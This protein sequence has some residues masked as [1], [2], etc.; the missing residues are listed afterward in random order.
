VN[1]FRRHPTAAA[2]LG[3]GG[4]ALIAA[5]VV[6]RAGWFRPQP[7]LPDSSRM[8]VTATITPRSHYFGDIVNA[9][10]ELLFRSDR[11]LPSSVHV[12]A[13]FTPL[14]VVSHSLAREDAGTMTRLTYGFRVWCVTLPC[15]AQFE[16]KIAPPRAVVTYTPVGRGPKVVFVKWPRLTLASRRLIDPQRSRPL[17][18]ATVRPL[19]ATTYGIRPG[20]LAALAAAGSLLLLLVAIVLLVPAIPRSL[21]VRRPSWLRRRVRP[22]TPLQQALERVRVAS[23]NGGG[24]ERRALEQLA[25]ELAG[26]GEDALAR[27]ARRL[28]WSPGRP[29]ADGVDDLSSGVE[30]VIGAAR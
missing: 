13:P 29:S 20:L 25:V 15:L 26:T 18:E 24:D 9:R 3:I 1:E 5:V 4:L 27:D 14:S 6:W 21:G 28:A 2:M 23:A 30:R 10:L 8:A 11:V 22:L 19:P 17:L 12:T 7:S 16:R